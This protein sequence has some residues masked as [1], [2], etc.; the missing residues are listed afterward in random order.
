[1]TND[2]VF[3][4]EFVTMLHRMQL[5]HVEVMS[6]QVTHRRPIYMYSALRENLAAVPHSVPF[7]LAVAVLGT[8]ENSTSHVT[9]VVRH[10]IWFATGSCCFAARSSRR[11]G[12]TWGE[13]H[14]NRLFLESPG[15]EPTCRRRDW[16][17][18]LCWGEPE[19]T[20]MCTCF[21]VRACRI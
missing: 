9:A 17:A 6:L 13:R 10:V 12:A 1:M 15:G 8:F 3:V 11:E 19:F 21:A 2:C 7:Q 4:W 14:I 20:R 5:T 16:A 18:S